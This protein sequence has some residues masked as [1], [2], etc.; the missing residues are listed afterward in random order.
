MGNK[1][2]RDETFKKLYKSYPVDEKGDL[3]IKESKKDE[4]YPLKRKSL[5]FFLFILVFIF[6]MI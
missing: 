6:P 2:Y 3:D 5:F 1:T 4:K